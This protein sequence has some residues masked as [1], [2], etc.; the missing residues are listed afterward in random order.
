MANTLTPFIPQIMAQTLLGLRE[1]LPMLTNQL[2]S[3]DY[4]DEAAEIGS[5]ISIPMVS[6]LQATDVVPSNTPPAAVDVTSSYV[7]IKFD[8]WKEVAVTF[9]DRDYAQLRQGTM[10]DC[11]RNAYIALGQVVHDSILS[12][13]K[14]FYG[15]VGTAGTTP[16]TGATMADA[17]SCMTQLTVQK[18]PQQGRY[19]ILGPVA[20]GQAA[21]VPA[22]HNNQYS[23][24]SDYIKTGL[25]GRQLNIEWRQSQS[26][27]YHTKGTGTLYQTNGVHA[28]GSTNIALDTGTGTLVVGDIITFSTHTQSYTVTAGISAPGTISI[29]P[30]LR[31]GL[32]DNVVITVVNSHTVNLVACKPAIAF[33]SRPQKKSIVENAMIETRTDLGEGGTGLSLHFEVSRQHYQDRASLSL[34]WGV[35]VV[36]PE[37]GVRL[38]G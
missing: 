33:V 6:A 25:L 38:L 1:E 3:I 22:F 21:M 5:T 37:F 20:Y 36:R 24:A 8:Y 19:A 29:S 23:P 15:F 4:G 30:A 13:Y 7:E 35:K 10:A 26:V 14:E 9:T 12:T 27:P 31:V 11:L 16:F 32:A 34:M 2:V 28:A 18:A 17:V